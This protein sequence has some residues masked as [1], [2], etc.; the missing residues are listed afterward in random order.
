MATFTPT[1]PVTKTIPTTTTD[2]AVTCK[3]SD[4][5]LIFDDAGAVVGVAGVVENYD[6]GSAIISNTEIPFEIR[7]GGSTPVATKL[8]EA[9]VAADDKGMTIQKAVYELLQSEDNPETGSPYLP[10]GA[11]A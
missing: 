8:A 6:S 9:A 7:D 5:R 1:T 3:F 10:A 4:L 11:I 2:D